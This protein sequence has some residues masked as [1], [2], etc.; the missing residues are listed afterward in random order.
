MDK[1][2]ELTM[3]IM[4]E[5]NIEPTENNLYNIKAGI[6]RED[7]VTFNL[8]Y[9]KYVLQYNYGMMA[10]IY[11]GNEI[12]WQTLHSIVKHATQNI[13]EYNIFDIN[14]REIRKGI[15]CDIYNEINHAVHP[16][17]DILSQ[18][19][20]MKEIIK[21]FVN[22]DKTKI[23]SIKT[24][25]MNE[26]EI[27]DALLDMESTMHIKI[28]LMEYVFKLPYSMISQMLN[29]YDAIHESVHAD[30][31][32]TDYKPNKLKEVD[33]QVNEYIMKI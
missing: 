9:Q 4:N 5:F 24:S 2:N 8:L 30:N 22:I 1:F 31:A 14:N 23:I 28:V 11:G 16:K 26:T 32:F 6:V 10:A 25:M 18:A 17:A 13:I 20:V 29:V 19:V 12:K 27:I 21:A 3:S 33:D 7:T 15:L